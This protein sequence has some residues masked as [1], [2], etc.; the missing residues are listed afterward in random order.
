[1]N[2][3]IE[4][5]IVDHCNLNCVGCAHFSPLVRKP[6]FKDL[7][8][9]GAEI[10]RLKDVFGDELERFALMGGEPL[11]HPD[12]I[13]FLEMSKQMLGNTQIEL[14]TNGILMAQLGDKFI[15]KLN[16]LK[17]KLRFTDYG[18]S[19]DKSFLDKLEL[20]QIE[21]RP[22][23]FNISLNLNGNCNPTCMYYH[24]PAV[25]KSW[26]GYVYSGCFMLRDGKMYQ[27]GVGAYADDFER[28][29][30]FKFDES[31]DN[32]G[33]S[34]FTHSKEQII[35][36]LTRP[37]EFCKYC[38]IFKLERTKVDFRC[39]ERKIEEWVDVEFGMPATRGGG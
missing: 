14:V 4:T 25:F 9:F 34:I 18:L 3:Y 26:L 19:I 24:C 38:N 8:E 31:L 39:S 12:I 17:V 27:C 6:R 13:A 21:D 29:F 32:M 11:L 15:D 1:M 22:K 16:E 33:I 2:Y 20:V 5:H 23:L 7:Q 30:N 37:H 10:A 35:D 28:Y 36:F